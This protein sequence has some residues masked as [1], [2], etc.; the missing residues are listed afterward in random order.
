[1]FEA[2]SY[3]S[4]QAYWWF[5]IALLGGILVFM[6][7]VQGGQTLLGKLSSNEDEKT[8]LINLFGHKWEITFTTLV[9][10]GG[11]FF[12]SFP[13][14][15]STSFGGAYYVWMIILFAFII[16]A[17]SYEYRK[18][19]NNFLGAKTYETFLFINGVIAPVF[20]GAAVSTF[21]TGSQFSVDKSRIVNM[22][23]NVEAVISQW[24][25]PWHGLEAIWTTQ[26]LA[27][28]QNLA[29]GLA[30]FFLARVIAL[31]YVKKMVADENILNKAQ[32]CL[33]RN[34]ILFLIF[35]L[36]WTV[37]LLFID[38]FA[39]DAET[40]KVF[41]APYK[42]LH[43]LLE[44]PLV[45]ILL[46]IGVVSVLWGIYTGIF[47]NKANAF[48]FAGVGTVLTVMAVFFIAAFNHT[49][50][51][52]STYDLQSSITLAN[53]ASSKFTLVVMSYVS[54]MVPFVLAYIIWAWKSMDNH[55]ISIKEIK[56]EEIKY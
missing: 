40:G 14:F 35:F 29:L 33:K 39:I 54:L 2:L 22:K 53:S 30:L 34:S 20:L 48:W 43:N 32:K 45:L 41:M 9:V 5:I 36:F 8:V 52:P 15:Y 47:K 1:M 17:V 38:G 49:A 10:F 21:F 56:Q 28:L 24:E 4:L 31:L 26:H 51:Y 19:K 7:F 12:A 50:Y 37:R 13:L 3:E 23:S 46:L 55:K 42:Y 16:Q 6:M 11:A 44:M 18:K 27:F 25:T